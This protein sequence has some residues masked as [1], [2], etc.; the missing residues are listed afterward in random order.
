[1][2]G[3]TAPPDVTDWLPATPDNIAKAEDDSIPAGYTEIGTG[4]GSSHR[5]NPSGN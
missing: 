1:V 3:N 4:T 2:T 5:T